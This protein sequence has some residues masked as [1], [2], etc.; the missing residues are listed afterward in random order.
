M[1]IETMLESKLNLIRNAKR[2]A[3]ERLGIAENP[4]FE[5]VKDIN[6]FYG[7]FVA[8]KHRLSSPFGAGSWARF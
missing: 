4:S 8:W 5:K 7:V 1:A 2:F 6:G 3:V